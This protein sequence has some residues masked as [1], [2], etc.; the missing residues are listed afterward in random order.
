MGKD[1]KRFDETLQDVR[2]K[3]HN[4]LRYRR[5]LQQE[6]EAVKELK[7]YEGQRTKR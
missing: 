3:N 1:K 6:E 4:K 5:R 2:S 7:E